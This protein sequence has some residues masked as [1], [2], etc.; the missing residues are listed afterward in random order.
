[1]GLIH[2]SAQNDDAS[3]LEEE[4]FGIGASVFHRTLF[5]LTCIMGKSGPRAMGSVWGWFK[6]YPHLFRGLFQ[7]KHT[8]T[9]G[10][11]VSG[12]AVGN[13]SQPCTGD[14]GDSCQLSIPSITGWRAI[15]ILGYF[16]HIDNGSN[17]RTIHL[18]L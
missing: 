9:Y 5:S 15:H 2:K 1:M 8:N 12:H 11:E 18:A 6:I 17:H 16:H 7:F 3:H 10:N 4:Y 13:G 14:L